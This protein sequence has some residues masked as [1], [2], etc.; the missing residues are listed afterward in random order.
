M[1]NRSMI[2]SS[3][4]LER[5]YAAPPA[6]VFAAWSS[7]DALSQWSIPAEGMT[8]RYERFE[9]QPGGA[10]VSIFQFDDGTRLIND[11][12]FADIIKNQRIASLYTMR[13]GDEP[14]FSGLLTVEFLPT[15]NGCLLRLHESGV[16]F[17]GHD[18]PEHHKLG[19]T[20]MLNALDQYIGA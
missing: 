5:K 12:V 16:F 20:A 3:L 4:N 19:Y 15:G 14:V 10:E 2:H 11:G 18:K 13:D 9:F 7:A 8:V 17:D 6:K 1:T